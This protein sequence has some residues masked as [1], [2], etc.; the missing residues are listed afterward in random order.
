MQG[1]H[2]RIA[3]AVLAGAWA[4][5]GYA[6]AETDILGK[7]RLQ[8]AAVAPWAE[9]GAAA[10]EKKWI[11]RTV[12]FRADRVKA[13]GPLAC[14]N[15]RYEATSMPA[16]GLFQG[17]L[18]APADAAAQTLGLATFPV[19][20]VSL[21][22]DTGIFEFHEAGEAVLFAL[23]NVIWTLD[24]S[25]GADAAAASPA[26]VV[27]A[28]LEA[29]FNGDMGFDETTVA[30]KQKWLSHDLK[31]AIVAYFAKPF[32]EDEVPPINGD[33]FTDSQEY[34]TRFSVGDASVAGRKAEVP[35]GY[36]DGFAKRSVV[37][38]LVKDG[39]RWRIDD[40]AFDHGG[41]F[42]SQLAEN[43]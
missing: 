26:G 17:G 9:E 11:G 31:A 2:R 19:D 6:H 37:F 23:D 4:L 36:A 24:R 8:R 12:E 30:A 21:T 27:Y 39:R 34:P 42:S 7:W 40:L 29:H 25:P 5:A 41:K 15:A 18:P 20:G 16:E 43:P 38:H 14:A 22:C 3:C 33:P 1:I 13:P 32:P 28:F 10:I 35:V